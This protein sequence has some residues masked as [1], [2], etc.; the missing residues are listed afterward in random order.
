MAARRPSAV[1]KEGSGIGGKLVW[2]ITR[3][4]LPLAIAYGVIWWRVD[5]GVSRVFDSI[6][7][8]TKASR[9][10]SFFGLNGD[11]GVNR[12]R[13]EATEGA[14]VPV[15]LRIERLT[16]HTPGL[17][18]LIRTSLIGAEEKFPQRMGATFDNFDLTG[19]PAQMQADNMLGSYSGAPFEA[20][21][22][23]RAVWDRADLRTLGLADQRSK[24]EIH[25]NRMGADAVEFILSAGTPGAGFAEAM[26]TL[27][28]PGV[29][30][31]PAA[32]AAATLTSATLTFRDEG[33]IAARNAYCAKEANITPAAFVDKHI[34]AVRAKLLRN[35]RVADAPLE[36]AYR[37]YATKGG[38]M[39]IR[40]RP[41][42]GFQLMNA[43]GYDAEQMRY[44]LSPVVEV[45]G[46]DP[47]LLSLKKASEIQPPPV[48]D[49]TTTTVTATPPATTAT[50][51]A[52]APAA[53]APALASIEAPPATATPAA[54]PPVQEA[55]PLVTFGGGKDA[56]SVQPTEY[57]ELR[58]AVGR[59]V[60]VRTH[61]GTTRRGVLAR[62]SG[63][64]LELQI[65]GSTGYQ[66]S[67]PKHDVRDAGIVVDG[68]APASAPVQGNR[69]AQ[70]N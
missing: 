58:Q 39:L 38:E 3:I 34:E 14:E 43:Q 62:F 23:G 4:G 48:A 52:A 37:D 8:F 9:G 32:F 17:W 26:I 11:V 44:L 60:V 54:P 55:R 56:F 13:I 25:L 40:A 57:D 31:N 42:A 50:T 68:A 18:W 27:N 35:D 36:A 20:E 47:V 7:M 64:S 21:G 15:S 29:E 53:T 10:S 65:G 59:E 41:Q 70:K 51:P 22:C 24:M 28:A 61:K 66:L 16:L 30:T 5:V 49:V 2:L 63:S 45:Q 46:R 19:I 69:N 67:I 12:V 1:K 33:F 6:Q